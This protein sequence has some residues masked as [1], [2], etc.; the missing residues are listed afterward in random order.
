MARSLNDLKAKIA[1]D[2]DDES[3]IYATE[4]ADAIDAAI[5][6]YAVE[7]FYFSETRDVTFATVSGQQW[8]GSAANANIPTLFKIDAAFI[9]DGSGELA[10]LSWGDPV[11][12]EQMSDNSASTGEPTTYTYFD[13]Q[14]RLYPVP[15]SAA[16]TVRLQIHNLA[17]SPASGSDTTSPW[18]NAAFQLIRAAAKIDL[19]LNTL[20]DPDLVVAAKASA[21]EWLRRLRR[22]T[23]MKTGSGRIVPM[24]F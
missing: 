20:R 10:E 16:Y 24:W 5:E 15:D 12:L 11:E 2:I 19:A 1:N 13:E 22:E 4:I 23:T 14:I 7:R 6:L 3:S 21:D 17:A 18:S 9:D 8:Y